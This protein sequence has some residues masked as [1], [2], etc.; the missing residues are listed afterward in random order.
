MSRAQATFIPLTVQEL[1]GSP[2]VTKVKYITFNGATLTDLLNGRVL[3]T[4]S[5]GGVPYTGA[6]ANVDLGANS[7]SVTDSTISGFLNFP[8]S[9]RIFQN[10]GNLYIESDANIG[11]R[12]Y[13]SGVVSWLLANDG[14]MFLKTNVWHPDSDGRPRILYNTNGAT[15]FY[16]LFDFV[17]S[18]R[19]VG[20][21][22]DGTIKWGSNANSGN[23]RG[24]LSWDTNRA[25][26]TAPFDIDL[27]AGGAIK[28]NSNTIQ[29]MSPVVASSASAVALTARAAAGQTA[30]ILEVQ[31]SAGTGLAVFN[32][33]GNLGLGV[34]SPATKLH[35]S[36]AM[37]LDESTVPATPASNKGVLW[38]SNGNIK[39][40]DKHLGLMDDA[41]N[42]SDLSEASVRIALDN[43][44]SLL[45]NP[46]TFIEQ[47][48]EFPR[49]IFLR[50]VAASP[51]FA[52]FNDVTVPYSKAM[53]IA[54][55]T[56][57]TADN[58]FPVKPA[59]QL[60]FEV[61]A[62]RQIGA[63]GDPGL[64]YFGVRQFDKDK[65]YIS[66][67]VGL[68]Y[69][70]GALTV[71]ADG[72]W[73]KYSGTVTLPTSHVPYM[74]SD[75]G[76]VRYVSPYLIVNYNAGTIPTYITGIMMRGIE[77]SNDTG[78]IAFS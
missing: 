68:Q 9:N 23:E 33:S 32:N 60:Y 12:D 49:N 64:L 26:I 77:N 70:F 1:G 37:T 42:I 18:V 51:T 22:S 69:A 19:G 15:N 13:S 50:P 10:S 35:I 58:Y 24:H 61:W 76:P 45:F 56:Y 53:L 62:M 16:G 72:I 5:G 63:T 11:L 7:L 4:V 66:S 34:A 48:V 47:E 71:P 8:T 78:P 39:L 21:Y 27:I 73:R 41:G 2:S 67:N 31:N 17:D 38:V 75:G 59:Q 3:V 52:E 25:I 74:G 55:Y 14:R 20:I 36:G 44:N 28:L 54:E 43:P 46:Q 6:T 30:N 57:F 29:A 65:N 40:A